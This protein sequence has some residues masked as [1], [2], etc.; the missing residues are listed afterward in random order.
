MCVCVCVCVWVS[1]MMPHIR[2]WACTPY[3][4]TLLPHLC[5]HLVASH[6]DGAG[7]AAADL[8]HQPPQLCSGL[9]HNQPPKAIQRSSG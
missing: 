4:G 8:L 9:N 6:A 7:E 3:N 2:A 5:Q 1:N